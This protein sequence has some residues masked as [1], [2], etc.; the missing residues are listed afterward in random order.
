MF[1]KEKKKNIKKLKSISNFVSVDLFSPSKAEV[2]LKP[3][4]QFLLKF[5]NRQL[6]AVFMKKK[7]VVWN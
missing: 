6:T 4:E 5:R 7:V 1:T 3:K 2:F